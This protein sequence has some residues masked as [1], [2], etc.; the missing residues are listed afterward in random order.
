MEI[1][2]ADYLV[3]RLHKL[4]GSH[5]CFI[6]SGGSIMHLLDAIG[7]SDFKPVSMHHEQAVVIASDAYGR[8]NNTIGVSFVTSGPGATNAITGVAGAWIESTPLIVISGQVSRATWKWN[9]GVR[10]M[11]FQEI[12]IIPIVKSITKYSEMILDPVEIRYHLEKAIYLAKSFC[13]V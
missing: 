2:L 4:T 5:H 6:F 1:R 13:G 3:D 8:V 10:Q 11:G 9:S 7:R 12:D